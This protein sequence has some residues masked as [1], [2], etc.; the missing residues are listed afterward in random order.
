MRYI[1]LGL[2]L[3]V[4]IAVYTVITG[5]WMKVANYIGEKLGLGKFCMK[6]LQKNKKV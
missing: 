5:I 3:L 2:L 1:Q 4:A 6:F